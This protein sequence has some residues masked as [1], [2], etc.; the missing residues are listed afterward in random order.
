MG[1]PLEKET[2]RCF[3]NTDNIRGQ[4]ERLERWNRRAMQRG[5]LKDQ[6][7]GNSEEFDLLWSGQE[8][9]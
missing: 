7:A 8:P 4:F 6:G 5:V 9:G 1:F 3:F 2:I